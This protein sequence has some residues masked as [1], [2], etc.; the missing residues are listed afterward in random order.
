MEQISASFEECMFR[1]AALQGKVKLSELHVADI[2]N[3]RV[4]MRALPREF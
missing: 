3:R 1:A 2:D 4:Q